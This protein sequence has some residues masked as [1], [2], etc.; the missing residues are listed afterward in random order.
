[1]YR[2]TTETAPFPFPEKMA[3]DHHKAA[4]PRVAIV[5]RIAMRKVVVQMTQL[6]DVNVSR[7]KTANNGVFHAVKPT[8]IALH[9]G[10]P[11][12]R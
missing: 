6:L 8:R 11:T 3:A 1:M 5:R 10:I 2:R 12:L 4:V 9:P 7:G